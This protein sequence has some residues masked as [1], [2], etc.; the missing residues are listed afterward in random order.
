VQFVL[1]QLLLTIKP[2]VT[3]HC[4]QINLTFLHYFNQVMQFYTETAHSTFP[5]VN[6]CSCCLV[7]VVSVRFP[8]L[9]V[10]QQIYVLRCETVSLT[11]NP[12]PGGPGYPFLSGSSPLTCLARDAIPIASLWPGQLSGSFDHTSPTTTSK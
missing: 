2:L 10:S 3:C 6:P 12:Q 11:T 1:N 8:I 5:L 7:F 9:Q 4:Y